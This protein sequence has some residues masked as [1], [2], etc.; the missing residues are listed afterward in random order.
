MSDPAIGQRAVSTKLQYY[1]KLAQ[2]IQSEDS[3]FVGLPPAEQDQAI[4]DLE[5]LLQKIELLRP[6]SIFYRP[7][8]PTRDNNVRGF[9]SD[10]YLVNLDK[11]MGEKITA[12]LDGA[13]NS[14]LSSLNG[15]VNCEFMARVLDL[16]KNGVHASFRRIVAGKPDKGYQAAAIVHYL[17]VQG[18]ITPSSNSAPPP[19]S[20]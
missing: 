14:Q 5:A 9:Y 12:V 16:K 20:P 15:R 1:Q 10:A 4:A 18:Y 11:E 3:T 6:R 13:A 19:N 2:R 7:N 8:G 17:I